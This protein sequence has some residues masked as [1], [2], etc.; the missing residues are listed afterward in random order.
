MVALRDIF[1]R[2]WPV[3]RPYRTWFALALGLIVLATAIETAQVWV[4]KDVV[5]RVLVPKD[6]GPFGWLAAA[7]VGLALLD[8]IIAFGD[9]YAS[10][11]VG[12]H[13]LLDLRRKVFAHL[14]TL[15]LDFFEGARLGD[16]MARLTGDVATIESFV[17]TGVADFVSYLARIVFFTGALFVLDW[18]LALLSLT[19]APLFFFAARRF[20]TRIKRASR[21]KRRRSGSISAVAE[22]SLA[23]VALVQASNRQAQ[24]VER[25][26]RENRGAMAAQLASTRISAAFGPLV[27]MIELGGA[28]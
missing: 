17:L 7:Y 5:D 10:T 19:V 16:L 8:G 22:E 25:F 4:F 2:F 20:S 3:A 27:T 15:S 14:H 13:F 21:E 26:E 12:E 28:L 11:W 1:R 18:R 24:E 6:L 23:N 9:E